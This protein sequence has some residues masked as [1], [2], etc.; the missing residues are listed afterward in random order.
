MADSVLV[1]N[2]NE[3][4]DTTRSFYLDIKKFIVAVI[5]TSLSYGAVV[6]GQS[7]IDDVG[8]DIGQYRVR[9]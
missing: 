3:T 5:N 9:L 6:N 7:V 4:A 2:A 8:F 1:D